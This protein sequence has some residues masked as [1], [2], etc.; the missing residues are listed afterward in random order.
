MKFVTSVAT[1]VALG[2]GGA[3]QA[4]DVMLLT[5]DYA[6]MN[7][8]RDGE[9]VGLGADQVFEMM[10]RAGI[11]Y[12]A[13]LTQW[14]R[15]IGQ[16]ERRPNTCVFSTT[17][18]EERDPNFQWVEP[19][20]S[21]STILV[22]KAG[23]DI[24]PASIDD[25]R[26]YRTGTQTGDYTVGVLEEAGFEAI[27]LAPSQSATLKKLLQGRIDLMA[28]SGSFLEAALADGAEIEEALVISTT[29]M[30]VACS[31]K[32]DQALVARMQEALQSMIDDGTQAEITA[33]YE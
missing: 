4:A 27:D 2:L 7:F 17:H 26:G 25:A 13:E 16:A 19:L 9:I 28:T 3:A 12:E 31:H 20:A 22:R 1:A 10:N 11:T 29:T 6:P 24:A 5:E 18:T 8:E 14:S 32:T 33:K 23:S 15:A 21:D 30:S